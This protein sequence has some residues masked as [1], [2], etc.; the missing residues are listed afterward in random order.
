MKKKSL[1]ETY[2]GKDNKLNSQQKIIEGNCLEVFKNILNNSIDIVITSPPYNIGIKYNQ[3]KDTLKR[4]QYLI[5]LD[6][7]FKEVKKVLKDDGSF[8]L[9]VGASSIDP[10][11]YIDVANIARK[12]FVL[13]NDITWV[14]SISINNKTSGHFKPINSKRFMNNTNEHIFHFT[15]S[16]NIKIQRESIGV[17]Y[18]D[19]SNVK[20]WNNKKDIRC[21]GNTWF[22]PYDT[23]HTR[24]Q[25][26]NHPASFPEKLVEWCIKLHGFNKDTIVCDP[27]CGSGT[28]LRVTKKLN[29][30][31]I[32]IEIDKTYIDYIKETL[33]YE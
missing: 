19:K 21:R 5:W 10:W 18:S 12:S 26:G 23:I 1:L 2:F 9:N 11:I 22:I 33:N 31:G 32:G 4:E 29:I 7:V 16:G 6:N 13:Q 25:R 15:K 27:F 3:Y 17:P 8:F 14:K 20:R 28:T 24:V 30:C